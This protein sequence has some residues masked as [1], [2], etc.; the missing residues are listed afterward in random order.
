[1][2][3]LRAEVPEELLQ[4]AEGGDKDA[5]FEIGKRFDSG[6]GVK[7]DSGK[8]AQWY[9]RAASKGH[10][11]AAEYL[12]IFYDEGIGVPKDPVIA[13]RWRKIAQRNADNQSSRYN[14]FAKP[15]YL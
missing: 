9:F 15:N 8:A 2:N 5:Q 12:A 14:V 10:A 3:P 6:Q 13:G 7:Q 4:K 11:K 1:M